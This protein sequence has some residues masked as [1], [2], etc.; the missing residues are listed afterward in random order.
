MPPVPTQFSPESTPSDPANSNTVTSGPVTTQPHMG[1][2]VPD[3]HFMV[4]PPAPVSPLSDT[5]VLDQQ[6]NGQPVPVVKVLSTRGVEYGMMTLALWVAASTM[7]WVILNLVNGSGGFDNVVVPT[8]ALVI[9]VPV[10]G[11]LFLR[12]KKA[13]MADPNLRL[14]PSKRRWSQTTQ[15]LAYIAV[16]INLIY[17]VYALLQK[18]GGNHAPSIVKS[19]INLLVILVIAGGILAYYWF[20][21]HRPRKVL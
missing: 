1:H 14:D 6:N 7:A 5:G 4:S 20:D 15:F 19:V 2:A 3:E 8:S 16:L 18:V 11:L 9:C 10:F 17:F 13:E 21:E 12:L